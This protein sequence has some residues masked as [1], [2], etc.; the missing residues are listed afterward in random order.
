[1]NLTGGGAALK[2]MTV[3]G[4]EVILLLARGLNIANFPVAHRLQM[5]V[6]KPDIDPAVVD[7]ELSGQRS[8]LLLLRLVRGY[9]VMRDA[10]GRPEETTF[11]IVARGS[12]EGGQPAW[13]VHASG[14]LE[15][16]AAAPSP[17]VVRTQVEERCAAESPMSSRPSVEWWA[18]AAD[19][20]EWDRHWHTVFD[21]AEP[22]GR[23][24]VGGTLNAAVNCLGRHLADSPTLA[25]PGLGARDHA[26]FEELLA[27]PA[28]QDHRCRGSG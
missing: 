11:E 2:S 27:D 7:H 8:A 6:D 19:G 10:E 1:M 14:M 3:I 12:K 17:R 13:T 20:L 23:W 26:Q 5:P 22:P 24:F 18:E 21:D 16:T 25:R 9:V 4:V 28:G 15:R